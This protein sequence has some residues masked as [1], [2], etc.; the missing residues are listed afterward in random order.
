MPFPTN[1]LDICLREI[2]PF[3]LACEQGQ[4]TV[5][6]TAHRD[7][8]LDA[9]GSCLAL[10]Q[11]IQR[12]GAPAQVWL[13]D[14]VPSNAIGL[15]GADQITQILP[16]NFTHCICLDAANLER[17]RGYEQLPKPFLNIDHHQDNPNFAQVNWVDVT[18]SS[19]GEMLSLLF[20]QV[21][22]EKNWTITSEIATC[23]Y[24]ALTF[25]TGRFLFS[26]TTVTSF[27]QA[28]WLLEQGANFAQVSGIFE[29]LQPVDFE[30][31]RLA[32]QNM[33]VDPRH[34][35]AYTIVENL[36]P[37]AQIKPIDTIRSLGGVEVFAAFSTMQG[38]PDEIKISLRSKGDF[39]VHQ[40]ATHF[41]GGGHRKAS[42]ISLKIPLKQAVADVLGQLDARIP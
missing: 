40:L 1:K 28:A 5:V 30:I 33:I 14:P 8:D 21:A 20:R 31:K 7:P 10:A 15:P 39:D 34:R 24:A 23:L 9:I 13:A 18:A 12:L 41:G 3:F 32:L 29:N 19:V 6:V 17:I 35:Y 36:D 4:A 16:A 11:F 26:N 27:N 42:G 22:T 2:T 38:S 25:D 37:I